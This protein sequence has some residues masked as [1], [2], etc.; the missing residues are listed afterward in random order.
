[1]YSH[2]RKLPGTHSRY[3]TKTSSELHNEIIAKLFPL[4]QLRAPIPK[5]KHFKE[6]NVASKIT[7]KIYQENLQDILNIKKYVGHL[8]MATVKLYWWKNLHRATTHPGLLSPPKQDQTYLQNMQEIQRAI[9]QLDNKW[10]TEILSDNSDKEV[11]LTGML[12]MIRHKAGW[13]VKV[14]VERLFNAWDH[15]ITTDLSLTSQYNAILADLT[16]FRNRN[17]LEH[18]YLVLEHTHPFPPNMDWTQPNAKF[19]SWNTQREEDEENLVWKDNVGSR[20]FVFNP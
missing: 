18:F 1:M 10:N 9:A 14:V 3:P 15:R 12:M 17:L 19:I 2:S 11:S 8:H 6:N 20:D 5:W 7:D 4:E 16:L 13:N